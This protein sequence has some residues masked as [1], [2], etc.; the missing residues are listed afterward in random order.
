M[1]RKII[2]SESA[3]DDL[4]S[5][6]EYISKDSPAYASIVVSDIVDA[7]RSLQSLAERGRRVPELNDSDIREL[8]I[9]SYRLVFRIKSDTVLILAI[10]HGR[11]LLKYAWNEKVR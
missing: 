1:D 8:F 6:A 10:I 9:H 3:A 4:E 5:I 7:G 2:W 11:R